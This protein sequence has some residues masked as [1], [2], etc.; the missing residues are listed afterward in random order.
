M[1]KLF[2]AALL[3]C[4]FASGLPLLGQVKMTRDQMMFYTADWKGDRFPDGRP[5]ISDALLTRALDVSIEDVWE[6]LRNLGTTVN[7]M[8]DGRHCTPKS[9]LLAAH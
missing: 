8:G 6:Y 4:L 2:K 9:H 7:T 3:G 1:Q 5:K